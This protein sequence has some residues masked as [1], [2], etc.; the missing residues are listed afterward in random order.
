M[1]FRLDLAL[2]ALLASTSVVDAAKIQGCGTKAVKKDIALVKKGLGHPNLACQWFNSAKRGAPML[3]TLNAAK[4]TKACE[5]ILKKKAV[6]KAVSGGKKPASF[7]A[8]CGANAKKLLEAEVKSPNRKQFCQF[9]TATYRPSKLGSPFKAMKTQQIYNACE[10]IDPAT[11]TKSSSKSS[12]KK[13]TTTTT[14]TTTVAPTTVL[15]TTVPASSSVVLSSTTNPVTAL[16]VTTMSALSSI[17]SSELFSTSLSLSL[18]SI[19]IL[20]SSSTVASS[21]TV[22]SSSTTSSAITSSSTV[23]SSST[24]SSAITSSSTV[25]SSSTT[26][27][28]GITSSSTASST[29]TLAPSSSS[30]ESSSSASSSSTAVNAPRRREAAPAA[31]GSRLKGRALRAYANLK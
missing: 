24:T 27:S 20:P 9:W 22:E 15:S 28:A 7:K 14:T 6:K 2:A 29:I 4:T 16:P 23:E 25:A 19:D 18:T 26:S 31:E 5:C 8:V 17:S 13:T 11:S 10:C 12:S 30:T 1:Y 3:S 21:S